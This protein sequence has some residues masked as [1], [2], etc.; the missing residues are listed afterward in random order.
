MNHLNSLVVFLVRVGIVCRGSLTNA[1]NPC[2]YSGNTDNKL[3]KCF[4]SSWLLEIL[5]SA[6]V[7]GFLKMLEMKLTFIAKCLLMFQLKGT[8]KSQ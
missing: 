6:L 3:W 7:S 8:L 2:C 4:F 1:S 5:L